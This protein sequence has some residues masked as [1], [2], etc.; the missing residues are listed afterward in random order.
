MAQVQAPQIP[1]PPR[2]PPRKV[3]PA[4]VWASYQVVYLTKRMELE[5]PRMALVASLFA[6]NSYFV[7]GPTLAS[8]DNQKTD[9]G[10]G[11]TVEDIGRG[12]KR[13]AQNVER[14]IPKI[15]PAIGETVKKIMGKGSDTQSAQSPEKQKQGLVLG[16]IRPP[17][18]GG[19]QA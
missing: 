6:L 18:S 13:A 12:L 10:K 17:S 8:S 11:I 2:D 14:A 4:T 19:F 1:P 3:A 15:G 5:M 9:G 16:A 7:A